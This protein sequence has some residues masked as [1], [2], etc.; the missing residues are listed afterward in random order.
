[1][2]TAEE[3]KILFGDRNS[4]IA[5]E[6][7][8]RVEAALVEGVSSLPLMGEDNRDEKMLNLL[9]KAYTK[10]I[11]LLEIYSGRNVFSVASRTSRFRK[12]IVEAFANKMTG[13]EAAA[14]DNAT[15]NTYLYVDLKVLS[16]NQSLMGSYPQDCC[17]L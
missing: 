8:E 4:L 14:N 13:E 6:F 2:M 3:D 5:D 1:M 16:S 17:N 12:R 10:H 11:D 7:C 15:T 9:R